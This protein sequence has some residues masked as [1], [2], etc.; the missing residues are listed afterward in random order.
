MTN[1]LINTVNHHIIVLILIVQNLKFKVRDIF[2]HKNKN[3][4]I[5]LEIVEGDKGK[6]ILLY[7]QYCK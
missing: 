3:Y 6:G 7:Q 2:I 1:D 5:L 4:R